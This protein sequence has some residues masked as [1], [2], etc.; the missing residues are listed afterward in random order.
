MVPIE[1]KNF[2]SVEM[3]KNKI[4]KGEPN[5]C[6]CQLCHNYLHGIEY[7]NLVDD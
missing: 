6:D 2:W 1:I 3:F 7:V 5:D 4:S